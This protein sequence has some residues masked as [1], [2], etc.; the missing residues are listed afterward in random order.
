[1]M[2]MEPAATQVLNFCLCL[3]LQ[4]LPTVLSSVNYHLQQA[5]LQ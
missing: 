5:F 2:G 4:S 1:L 3:L